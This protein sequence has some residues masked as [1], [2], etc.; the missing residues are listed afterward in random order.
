MFSV[1]DVNVMMLFHISSAG[2][3]TSQGSN[4]EVSEFSFSIV[5]LLNGN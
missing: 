5:I 4:S 2:I 1:F 3:K